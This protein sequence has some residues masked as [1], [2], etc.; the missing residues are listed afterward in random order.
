MFTNRECGLAI[1]ENIQITFSG[2]KIRYDSPFNHCDE[3]RGRRQE[4]DIHDVNIDIRML[5]LAQKL[6]NT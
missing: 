1:K 2:Q 5:L 6:W 4:I 3:I